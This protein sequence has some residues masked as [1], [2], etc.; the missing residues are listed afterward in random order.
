MS[1]PEW[2]LLIVFLIPVYGLLIW[3]YINPEDS[4]LLGK[5]WM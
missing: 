4:H 2:F 1:G 5:R 3:S